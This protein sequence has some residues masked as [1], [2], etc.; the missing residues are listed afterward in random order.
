MNYSPG[1][2]ND[3]Y[4]IVL[5]DFRVSFHADRPRWEKGRLEHCAELMEPGMVVYDIGAEHGDFTSLYR[6]WVDPGGDVC[7]IEPAAHYWPFIRETWDANGFQAA[8]RLCYVGLIGD[9]QRGKRADSSYSWPSE[10]YGEGIPDGGFL[11][12][13]HDKK[14]PRTTIDHLALTYGPVPDAIV[15]DIEGSEW[16]AVRGAEGTLIQHKPLLWISVHPTP[17][18]EWYHKTV[19]DLLGLLGQLGYQT[20]WL[21]HFGEG[22]DFLYAFPR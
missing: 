2:I 11:H 12:L 4:D 5:P 21:P 15:M 19:E 7:P 14:S 6:K 1:R 17:L 3:A 22:E 9:I 13:A 10:A 16:N 20:E 8:P 18:A